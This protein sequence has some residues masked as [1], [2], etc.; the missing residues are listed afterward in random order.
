MDT[1]KVTLVG[2]LTADPEFRTLENGMIEMRCTVAVNFGPREKNDAAF[3]SV[4]TRMN[5]ER[6]G[7]LYYIF[8]K[9][10][11]KRVLVMGD[12]H[13][14]RGQDGKNYSYLNVNYADIQMLSATDRNQ[15][16]QTTQTEEQPQSEQQ[17]TDPPSPQPPQSFQAPPAMPQP[18][19]Q[20]AYPTPVPP[21]LQPQ[22]PVPNMRP[23]AKT[24]S[25]PFPPP[26][27]M[28]G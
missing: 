21:A 22:P 11:G 8:D 4:T 13:P 2:N 14:R 10:K 24:N 12:L 15:Q 23:P 18:M 25:N 3:F 26:P 16:P 6:Y 27:P 20:P 7:K 1:S 17:Y 19:P 9:S 28:V 5:Q